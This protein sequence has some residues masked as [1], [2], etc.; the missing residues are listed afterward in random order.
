M[1]IL[2]KIPNINDW[3]DNNN[4][5]SANLIWGIFAV[6]RVLAIF[7]LRSSELKKIIKLKS[8]QIMI[9]QEN[10]INQCMNVSL[11]NMNCSLNTF[12]SSMVITEYWSA[13]ISVY[14]RAFCEGWPCTTWYIASHHKTMTVVS[15][16]Y[17]ITL[18]T[19][20]PPVVVDSKISSL[21]CCVLSPW[22]GFFL[23]DWITASRSR[24]CSTSYRE[25]TD[26]LFIL[27]K[28]IEVNT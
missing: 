15:L 7:L 22:S 4:K 14:N 6:G 17:N 1:C 18:I 11:T 16:V 19:D 8:F 24:V 21:S 13:N 27:Y 26:L 9:L 3:V 20:F 12:N 2:Y 28:R 10:C 23:Q 5:L 25:N